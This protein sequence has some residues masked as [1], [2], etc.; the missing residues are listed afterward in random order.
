MDDHGIVM[1]LKVYKYCS[2]VHMQATGSLLSVFTYSHIL[3]FWQWKSWMASYGVNRKHI[4]NLT[5]AAQ[6]QQ[7]TVEILFYNYV[8]FFFIDI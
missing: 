6:K 5:L 1:L 4:R 3:R 8:P 7:R 2:A